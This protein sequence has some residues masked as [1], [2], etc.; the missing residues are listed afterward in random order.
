MAKKSSKKKAVKAEEKPPEPEEPEEYMIEIDEEL[1]Q[2]DKGSGMKMLALAVLL[3]VVAFLAYHFLFPYGWPVAEAE[4]KDLFSSAD[5]IFILMD[6]RGVV[7]VPTKRNILQCGVDFAGSTGMVEK[8]VT[9][10]AVDDGNCTA[11]DGIHE[12][13]YCFSQLDDG[14]TIHIGEGSETRL[15]S[16]GMVVGVGPNY[17]IG[18]CGIHRV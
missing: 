5:R 17:I 3:I 2:P 12:T 9:Y 7:D 6:T 14:M 10:L 8:N 13:S 16:N 1:Q 18:T 4:F 11:R 15:Y